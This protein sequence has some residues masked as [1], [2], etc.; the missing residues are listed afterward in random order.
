[1]VDR[2][3]AGLGLGAVLLLL[4]CCGAPLLVVAIGSLGV[5]ALLAWGTSLIWPVAGLA[6]VAAAFVLYSRFRRTRVPSACC[7]DRPGTPARNLR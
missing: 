1:M 4:V 6:L 7:D 2:Q 3:A 5:S